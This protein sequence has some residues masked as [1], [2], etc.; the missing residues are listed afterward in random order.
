MWVW[1]RLVKM[2]WVDKKTNAEILNL[3]KEQKSFLSEMRK[4][5][6]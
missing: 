4:K 6:R 2:K 5:R 3:V 1:R